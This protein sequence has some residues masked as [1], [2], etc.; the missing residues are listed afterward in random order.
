MEDFKWRNFR[1]SKASKILNGVRAA[2]LPDLLQETI[3]S[4]E[5]CMS[6][7]IQLWRILQVI[8]RFVLVTTLKASASLFVLLP[9]HGFAAT[10]IETE[11]STTTEED[12]Y[13]TESCDYHGQ[14]KWH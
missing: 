4:P 3:R 6:V 9:L 12:Y 5:F 11:T 2:R 1:Q 10:N 13:E 14:Y 8:C 7:P